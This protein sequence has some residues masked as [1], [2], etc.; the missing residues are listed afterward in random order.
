M[1]QGFLGCGEESGLHLAVMADGRME[2]VQQGKDMVSFAS[3]KD[4]FV[5]CV[6]EDRQ[7]DC[8]RGC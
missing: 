6:V 2:G 3:Y 8:F 4:P 1:L 5:C 7:G